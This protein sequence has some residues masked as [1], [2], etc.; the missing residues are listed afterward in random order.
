MGCPSLSQLWRSLW[1]SDSPDPQPVDA[2]DK[3]SVVAVNTASLLVYQDEILCL[4][5]HNGAG[6]TTILS[7]LC[8]LFDPTSGVAEVPHATPAVIS[9]ACGAVVNV[10]RSGDMMLLLRCAVAS[11]SSCCCDG[12]FVQVNGLSLPDQISDVQR[13]MGVCPQHD[14]LWEELT[15]GWA[16]ALHVVFAGYRLVF[17]CDCVH[18]LIQGS[19]AGALFFPS[20]FCCG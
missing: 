14:I 1:H 6:K 17:A 13:I 2:D 5:G 10:L 19:F 11:M 4:L 12:M 18:V 3:R 16:G 7:I 8:G 20:C 15:G 9:A